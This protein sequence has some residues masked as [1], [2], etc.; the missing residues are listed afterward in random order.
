MPGT[1]KTWGTRR[2]FRTTMEKRRKDFPHP[3]RPTGPAKANEFG[4]HFDLY[5]ACPA[6]APLGPGGTAASR[7]RCHTHHQEQP[8]EVVGVVE[9]TYPLYL[10]HPTT[11]CTP[12]PAKG[13]DMALIPPPGLCSKTVCCCLPH[14]NSPLTLAIHPGAQQTLGSLGV[15]GYEL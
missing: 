10:Q 3:P 9:H 1:R 6:A 7:R 2:R 11:S 5:S 12:F 13:I 15:L 8:V 4:G 14:P